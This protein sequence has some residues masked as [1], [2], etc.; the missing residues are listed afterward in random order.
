MTP[1]SCDNRLRGLLIIR[2]RE[3]TLEREARRTYFLILIY[4]TRLAPT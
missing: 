2:W 1:L 3:V 4:L